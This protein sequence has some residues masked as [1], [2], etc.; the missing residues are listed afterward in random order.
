ME[1]TADEPQIAD[2]PQTAFAR[3]DGG[4][5]FDNP[6]KR[7]T[8]GLR[9]ITAPKGW[10]TTNI[11]RSTERSAQGKWLVPTWDYEVKHDLRLGS[12]CWEDLGE[13]KKQ[14]VIAAYGEMLKKALQRH[15]KENKNEKQPN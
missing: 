8:H 7:P 1:K 14:D 5:F 9:I 10:L 4:I 15:R 12:V 6:R 13:E 11:H 2:E 3:T